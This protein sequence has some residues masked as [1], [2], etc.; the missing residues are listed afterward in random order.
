VT[1]AEA[2][3]PA[4]LALLALG[5][6]A[7]GALAGI[8]A[9]LLGVGGGIAIVPMLFYVFT[10]LGLDSGLVMPMAVATSLATILPTTLRSAFAHHR[11]GAVEMG[12]LRR[13]MPAMVA[14]VAL[15]LFL[16]DLG[17]GRLMLAVFAAVAM[18]FA[19]NLAFGRESWR[20]AE[21]PPAGPILPGIGF[22]IGTISAMMGIGAGTLGVTT[23]TLVG[24]PI[25]RAVATAA[26]L[27]PVIALPGAIGFAVLGWDVPGRPPFSVGYINLLGVALIVPMSVATAPLG[28]RLAHA[29]DQRLLRRAFAAFLAVT[30]LR[31]FLEL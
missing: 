13:W 14:G 30:A 6:A 3:A 19:L 12:L 21:T 23:M 11:R 28:V 29:M 31:M 20:L 5:V 2:L 8:L 9:G 26:A 1:G 22:V 4:T 25:R 18:L 15:G 10:M 16:A 17:G 24:V 27:G 7:T